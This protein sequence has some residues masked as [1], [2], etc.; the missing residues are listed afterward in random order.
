MEKALFDKFG[1]PNAYIADDF[2][3]T[4]YLWDGE[5]V[6]YVYEDRHVYGL[7]GRH[8]GWF[9]DEVIYDQNG[10][11]IGFTAGTCPVNIAELPSKAKRRPR[12]E[13]RPRSMAPPLPKL[14]HLAAGRG[15]LHFL[16]DGEVLPP[17]ERRSNPTLG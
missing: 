12:H 8:L 10:E 16:K 3:A 7:N 17:L 9:I 6:A 4:I 1:V 11:R 5:A 14:T 2:N 15:L 13:T